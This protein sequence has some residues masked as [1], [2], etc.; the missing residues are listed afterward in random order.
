[1]EVGERSQHTAMNARLEATADAAEQVGSLRL[2]LER[3]QCELKLAGF[4]PS[5]L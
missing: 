4:L 3:C 5:R 1:M 2:E